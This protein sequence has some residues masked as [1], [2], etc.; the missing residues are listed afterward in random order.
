MRTYKMQK[1]FLYFSS[2]LQ[3]TKHIGTVEKKS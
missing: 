1:Q 2:A 3:A